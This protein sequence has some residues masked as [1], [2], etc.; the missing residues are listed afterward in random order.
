MTVINQDLIC[1]L[2]TQSWAIIMLMTVMLPVISHSLCY[3]QVDNK[4]YI[5]YHAMNTEMQD[6]V[7][8]KLPIGA[9]YAATILDYKIKDQSAEATIEIGPEE[10]EYFDLLMLLNLKWD[11]RNPGSISGEKPVQIEMYLDQEVFQALTEADNLAMNRE[12][13][14]ELDADHPLLNPYNWFATKVTEEIDLPPHLKALG[15]AREGFTTHW[16]K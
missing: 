3:A 2:L 4:E 5:K 12:E 16:E 11:V 8:F 6:T 15:T 14:K 1:K 7:W 9:T 13:L 10:W